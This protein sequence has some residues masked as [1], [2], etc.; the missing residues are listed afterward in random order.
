MTWDPKAARKFLDSSP[1]TS[2]VDERDKLSNF[3][4]P[5]GRELA[6]IEENSKKVSVY[7]FPAP[8]NLP[9]AILEERYPPT[10]GTTGRHSNLQSITSTLGF[11]SEACRMHIKDQKALEDLL[12]WY[13][14]A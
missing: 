7:V 3:R 5:N 8:E 10:A 9:N 6:L 12:H 14:Y 13:K 11:R 1:I 2:F 4:L